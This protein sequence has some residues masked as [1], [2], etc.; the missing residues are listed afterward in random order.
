MVVW[1]SKVVTRD[2]KAWLT[3][4]SNGASQ[5]VQL[6]VG[7]YTTFLLI[8]Y[9]G[10]DGY[11]M[12][13]VVTSIC[14]WLS[15]LNGGLGLSLK[16]FLIKFRANNDSEDKAMVAYSSIFWLMLLVALSLGVFGAVLVQVLPIDT[17]LNV[18]SSLNIQ[19]VERLVLYVVAL[20]LL[21]IPF[22]LVQFVYASR[23]E[24]YWMLPFTL[25]GAFLG[26]MFVQLFIGAELPIA[27][28]GSAVLAGALLGLVLATVA[29]SYF[30]GSIPLRLIWNKRIILDLIPQGSSFFVI[31]LAMIAIYQSDIFIVNFFI[32]QE[33]S[34]EY[35]LHMR[36]VMLIQFVCVLF[37]TP[38]WGALGEAWHQGDRQWFVGK[39]FRLH[40]IAL[41][42]SI[43]LVGLIVI[44]GDVLLAYWSGETIAWNQDLILTLIPYHL[45][46]AV[47]SISATALSA[48]NIVA[49]PA[50]IAVANA[51]ANVAAPA[52]N[53]R[54]LC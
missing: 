8:Q 11:G 21:A 44:Y 5:G 31:Q 7:I 17:L 9:L 43:P 10:A 34:A 33:A 35:A 30:A 50:K 52:S 40:S 29:Q 53:I 14:A 39:L 32:G 42:V 23:Q 24:E 49:G 22:R 1:N 48:L 4:F 12:V 36:I 54:S 51:V 25:I 26:L 15:I 28:V 47:I 2:K 38:F 19:D 13:A 27:E 45:I 41:L 6:L 18:G 16:N 20:V 46:I 37:V 3:A